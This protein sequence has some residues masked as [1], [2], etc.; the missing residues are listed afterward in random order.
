MLCRTPEES[1]A[2]GYFDGEGFEVDRF[3][4]RIFR[5]SPGEPLTDA[6]EAVLE[7]RNSWY[8]MTGQD[9]IWDA[10]RDAVIEVYRKKKGYKVD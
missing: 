7:H 8:R 2:V 3:G 4:R 6:E 1:F 5:S 10:L 9:D